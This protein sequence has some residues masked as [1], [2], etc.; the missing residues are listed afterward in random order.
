MPFLFS[1]RKSIGQGFCGVVALVVAAGVLPASVEAAPPILLSVGHTSGHLTAEWSL[2]PGVQPRVI[3]AA[4]SPETGSDGYF[5]EENVAEFETLQDFQTS[6]V[7]SDRMDPGTYYVHVAGYD[8]SCLECDVREFSAVMAVT[9][10]QPPPPPPK[11]WPKLQ[12]SETKSYIRTALAR[13]FGNVYRHGYAKRIAGCERRSR[14]RVRC[15]RVS[16]VIGDLGYRGWAAIWLT[17][18]GDEFFWN[19]AYTIKRTNYYCVNRGGR[20]CTKTYRVS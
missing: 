1:R 5:F 9:I 15:N 3:E 16:W 4:T 19:Y 6:F 20:N 8:D 18:D 17:R 10:P 12:V 2:P 14:T 13:R 7:A 11:P